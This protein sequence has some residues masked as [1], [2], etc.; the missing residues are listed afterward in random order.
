MS[1]YFRDGFPVFFFRT[2]EEFQRYF[3]IEPEFELPAFVAAQPD[4]GGSIK[5][6]LSEYGI[7]AVYSYRLSVI[8]PDELRKT[9]YFVD[10]FELLGKKYGPA[11][12]LIMGIVNVTPDSFYPGSRA[13]A[14]DEAL[15]LAQKHVEEGADIL[16]VGGLSTRPG[17]QEITVEEEMARVIPAIREI[18]AAFDVPVSIDTYRSEVAEA[19]LEAGASIVNDVFGFRK[20]GMMELLARER[21]PAVLMHMKG[22]SPRTMQKNPHYDDVVCEVASFFRH[23][24]DRLQ[25]L[26]GD[27]AAVILDPGIGFGKRYED[28]LDL[29]KHLSAFRTSGLPLLVGHSRKSFIGIAAG[30][31]EPENRLPGTIA[32]GAIAVLN[33]A[34]ILRV[35]DV[36]EAVQSARIASELVKR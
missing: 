6:S 4:D 3:G 11:S 20:P 29:I 34:S 25:Q 36:A 21:V 14:V 17:A 15:R 18:T 32:A 31:P 9:G 30:E 13:A 16:D 23:Q 35:H 2:A 28:N 10:E 1:G 12:P 26:G 27:P 24:L 7:D 19:A 22:D 8:H 5:V 33:G